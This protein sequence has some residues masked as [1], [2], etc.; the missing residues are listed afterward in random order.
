MWCNEIIMMKRILIF[1][2]AALAAGMVPAASAEPGNGSVYSESRNVSG[3]HGIALSGSADVLYTPSDRYEVIVEGKRE[4]VLQYATEIRSGVLHLFMPD[5]KKKVHIHSHIIVKVCA[6]NISDLMLSGSGSISVM[7]DWTSK[8]DINVACSGSGK[9][10]AGAVLAPSFSYRGSGSSMIS[11]E[12]IAV[13]ESITMK[14]SGSGKICVG[15]AGAVKMSVATT[16]SGKMVIG[17]ADISGTLSISISGSGSAKLGG[18]ADELLVAIS[19]SGNVGGDL[20]YGT[21]R[22]RISGSGRVNL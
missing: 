4:D 21:I 14:S 16:G 17:A 11:A 19:G 13:R 6:P 7:A 22:T 10:M 9:I 18:H 8:H 2:L 12:S 20:T 5:D 15:N 1:M 3:F